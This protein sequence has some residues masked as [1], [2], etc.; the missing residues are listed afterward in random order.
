MYEEKARKLENHYNHLEA[1][2]CDQCSEF[3]YVSLVCKQVGFIHSLQQAQ[4]GD[5]SNQG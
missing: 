2:K 1:I 4:F 3:R 5:G